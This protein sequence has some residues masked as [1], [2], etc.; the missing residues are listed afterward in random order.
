MSRDLGVVACLAS[1]KS[2]HHAS[3][4]RH[5]AV[6]AHFPLAFEPRDD[7]AETDN[8]AQHD[9]DIALR[10]IGDLPGPHFS[11]FLLSGQ[12]AD[13]ASQPHR[14]L[15][16]LRTAIGVNHCV[17]QVGTTLPVSAFVAYQ[18]GVM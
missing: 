17:I 2:L 18:L 3:A 10:R 9:L 11:L 15:F 14:I 4:V 8:A 12:F 1:A 6:L 5:F 7:K 13:M 16:D